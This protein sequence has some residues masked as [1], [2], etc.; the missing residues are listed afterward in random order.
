MTFGEPLWFWAF[1]LLPLLFLLFLNNE[2]KRLKLI[3]QLVAARLQDRLA[4]SV[5]VGKRRLR[6]FLL[7]AGIACV[8]TALT[9]PRNGYD[10]TQTKRKGRDILIAIDT[11]RSMLA[12]DLA[13]DRLTRAKLAAQDLISQLSGDR[14][15]LIAFA[16]NAFLQAP[17]TVDYSAVLGA[18]GEID[19]EIIPEG[20]TN[21]AAALRIAEDAFGKGES[22][23]R[24][25]IILTD[26]EEL[27]D[28]GIKVAERLH[29]SVTIFT[30]GLGSPEG[31]LI[32]LPGGRG[33]EFVKD[34]EGQIVKSRLDE[35]RLSKIAELTG[36]FYLRL[37][38]GMAD[39]SRVVREGLGKMTEHDIDSK[40]SR[41][42]TE[43]YEWP[44][45]AGIVLLVASMLV[46]ERRNS[47]IRRI[48][49]A[50]AVAAIL[51][52]PSGAWAKNSGVEAYEKEDYKGALDKFSSQL[53]LQP[54]SEALHFDLGSAAY[55]SGD[56]DKALESFSRAVT[57]SDP[58]LRA[59]AE[60]NLGNTLYQRGA[61]QKQKE[62]KIQEWQNALQHYEET[63]K[64]QPSNK[65]AQFN[66]DLIKTLI[67][68][69]KKE[70]PKED[71]KD[72]KQD[73]QDD[74]KD[75]KN[76]DKKEQKKDGKDDPKDSKDQ[77]GE[78]K[79]SKDQ[80]DSKEQ[81]SEPKDGHDS[82]DQKGESKDSK[83]QE[84]GKDD[85][86]EPPAPGNKDSKEGEK[87]DAPQ[88]SD[89]A[90]DKGKKPEGELKS[91]EQQGA[92]ENEPSE[93]EQQAAE[94]AAAAEGKMTEKQA[95][96]LLESLKSE[97]RRVQLLKPDR[98][99]PGRPLRDW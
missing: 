92:Q 24:A 93:A 44:L 56:F 75:E 53:K 83:D 58:Q 42:P 81:K 45:A 89:Q 9:Q 26:G 20:G 80:K 1:A 88:P 76:E 50:S 95:K 11:S 30:L 14:V 12:T 47:P 51:L 18:L 90:E 94:E 71:K 66:R 23:H 29:G 40:L 6:F 7:L 98:K 87:K 33:G 34:L 38:N 27:E 62:P 5:S 28:E 84:G 22:D 77:K 35:E 82:K 65:D 91:A 15:G 86:K 48:A 60:Y 68:D 74:K 67:A 70:P 2:R 96:N 63:L 99:N 10:W 4:G 39:T 73:K 41:Q 59:K 32:P 72:E 19:T 46:G 64:A 49:T 52:L 13:P 3:R 97:D 69:L 31:S 25:I 36:G 16:G 85:A 61:V 8:I 78:P 57:S 54:K 79:D 17:L 21:I 55:K 37:Q 43:R